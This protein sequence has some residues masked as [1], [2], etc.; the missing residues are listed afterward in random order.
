MSE[1]SLY[2]WSGCCDQAMPMLRQQNPLR[3]QLQ[4]VL[5]IQHVSGVF[6]FTVFR[7]L[8][9]SSH[10][11]LGKFRDPSSDVKTIFMSSVGDAAID[12]PDASVIVQ[13]LFIFAN[14]VSAG[15]SML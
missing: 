5:N 3:L 7:R 9:P 14:L 4:M 13:V 11:I 12:L 6:Y 15:S 2:G 8:N 10:Q 1:V